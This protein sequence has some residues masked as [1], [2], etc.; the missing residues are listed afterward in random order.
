MNGAN[1]L[2][3]RCVIN[4]SISKFLLIK[5]QQKHC[6]TVF[7][8]NSLDTQKLE[9]ERKKTNLK[10]RSVDLT[11]ARIPMLCVCINHLQYMYR[12]ESNEIK[13]IYN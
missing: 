12:M 5:Q 7:K 11:A 1:K 9:E 4:N 3:Q 10:C 6:V 2:D 13:C 8:L